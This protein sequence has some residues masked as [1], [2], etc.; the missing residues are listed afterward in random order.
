[1]ACPRLVGRITVRREYLDQMLFGNKY[2]LDKKLNFFQDYYNGYRVHGALK[3]GPPLS[4]SGN[5]VLGKADIDN[6]QWKSHCRGLFQTPMA[7]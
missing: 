6:Y 5:D 1:M 2:D 4:I 7:A 3:G